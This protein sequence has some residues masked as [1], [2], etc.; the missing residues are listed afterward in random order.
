MM[1]DFDQCSEAIV[2]PNC[3]S[4]QDA[5]IV[6]DLGLPFPCYVHTCSDCGRVILE[7]EWIPADEPE[8]EIERAGL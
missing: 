7:S 6:F 3:Q 8:Y 4:V 1:N 5:L 2:C